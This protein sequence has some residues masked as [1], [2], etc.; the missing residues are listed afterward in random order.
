MQYTCTTLL[1]FLFSDFCKTPASLSLGDSGETSRVAC[2]PL[3][4]ASSPPPLP[5]VVSV[6]TSAELG[7]E[8][9]CA[10]EEQGGVEVA[11]GLLAVAWSWRT[12]AFPSIAQSRASVWWSHLLWP[13]GRCGGGARPV[14]SDFF[15][16]GQIQVGAARCLLCSRPPADLT[17]RCAFSVPPFVAAWAAWCWICRRSVAVVARGWL[18]WAV[19]TPV[20]AATWL[21]KAGEG[22]ATGESPMFGFCRHRWQRRPAVSDP[23]FEAPLCDALVPRLL[24]SFSR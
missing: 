7:A 23:S 17:P 3:P 24:C 20:S 2:G 12:Q 1:Y 21:G 9:R 4:C 10:L 11:R 8:G 14:A 13:L 18:P 19:V 15:S 5:L 6:A 22:D 16:S